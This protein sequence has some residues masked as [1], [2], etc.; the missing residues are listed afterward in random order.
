MKAPNNLFSNI[1]GTFPN[2]TGKN[3]SGAGATDGTEFIADAI[4][5]Y[6]IGFPQFALNYASIIPSGVVESSSASQIFESIQKGNGIGPG[7]LVGW[8]LANDP[9][10][11][12]YRVLLMQGQGILRANYQAL[13][14][15][16][17]VGDGSNAAV[18]AGGGAFYRA[19]D[20][21]GTT[22]NTTGIYLILPETRGYTLRGLDTAATIDPDGASR[23][24]GDNQSDALQEITGNLLGGGSSIFWAPTSLGT[25]NGVFAATGSSPASITSNG[26]NTSAGVTFAASNSISP[27]A[28]KTNAVETRM[29]NFS[30]QL[31]ITY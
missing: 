4:N 22:P 8:F 21:A 10:I 19:D 25:I 23:F 5:D 3:A 6:M 28:A 29:S 27:N 7:V 18:A 13:D 2:A 14:N 24:L 12:G 9:S 16:V 15:V 30:I 17:Y 11:A 1:N 20:A 26:S 31:G